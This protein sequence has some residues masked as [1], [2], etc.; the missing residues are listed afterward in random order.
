MMYFLLSECVLLICGK[1]PDVC[2]F[3][4]FILFILEWVQVLN[5]T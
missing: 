2:L 3:P 4:V 5:A 1:Q